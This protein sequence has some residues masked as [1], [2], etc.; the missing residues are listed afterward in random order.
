MH[1]AI[2]K[3]SWIF[4]FLSTFSILMQILKVGDLNLFDEK[5]EARS[6][7]LINRNNFRP[8]RELIFTFYYGF[9]SDMNFL[10]LRSFFVT[11][12]LGTLPSPTWGV[13]EQASRKTKKLLSKNAK[14]TKRKI[15]GKWPNFSPRLSRHHRDTISEN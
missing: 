10:G 8:L 7:S 1:L 6:N 14:K 12:V 4:Q 3:K 13:F 11:H 9:E 15:W 5:Y 2:R